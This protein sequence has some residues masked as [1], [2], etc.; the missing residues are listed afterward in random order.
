[1][2][3]DTTASWLLCE[4][5]H[6]ESP[7][8]QAHSSSYSNALETPFWYLENAIVMNQSQVYAIWNFVCVIKQ[9]FLS[10]RWKSSRKYPLI[11]TRQP[12]DRGW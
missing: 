1:V 10:K 7:Q 11:V 5:D 6:E 4:T 2:D 8:Y 9:V 3:L 12:V